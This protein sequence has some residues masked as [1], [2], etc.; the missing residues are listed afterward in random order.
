MKREHPSWGA[1]KIRERLLPPVLGYS[2]ARPK[3]PS[4]RFWIVM[5]WWSAAAACVVAL[6]GTALSLGQRP[7]ELWCTDYK[8]EFLLGESCNTAIR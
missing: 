1:R 5:D 7:N 6:K 2:Y 8:G 3:A 4:M